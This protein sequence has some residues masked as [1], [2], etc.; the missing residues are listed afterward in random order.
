VDEPSRRT[1]KGENLTAQDDVP[2]AGRERSSY[3]STEGITKALVVLLGINF[4]IFLAAVV[5]GLIDV[6]LFTRIQAGEFITDQQLTTSDLRQVIIGL[7]QLTMLIVTG[8][9]FLVWFHRLYKNMPNL[10]MGPLRYGTGWAIGAW[11]VP[12]LN[13]FRPKQIMND[14]WRA[15]DGSFAYSPGSFAGRDVSL[16]VNAWWGMLLVSGL[17][18]RVASRAS[19][20]TDTV[21][22][23][24]DSSWKYIISDG[25]DLLLLLATIA[26]ALTL[27]SR[28][29]THAQHILGSTP[30]AASP[31]GASTAPAQ[32]D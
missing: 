19:F 12:I 3:R 9:I 27:S 21:E 29:R 18:S 15:S 4:V 2:A 1:A 20:E 32:A 28:Q 26:V 22:E 5:S 24:L 10:G 14:I 25:F 7:G 17:L 11:F 13:L 31:S 23:L 16:L 30:S 6:N 8:I